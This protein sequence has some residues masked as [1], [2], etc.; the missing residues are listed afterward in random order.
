MP[1]NDLLYRLALSCVPGI[2]PVYAKKLLDR[3]GDAEAIFHAGSSGLA[4]VKGMGE[5]RVNA[6]LR[7]D[8]FG[9]LEKEM[10]FLEKYGIR[11]LF[12]NEKE[13]PQRLCRCKEAPILFYYKGNADLNAGRIISIVG[14][15][16]PTEYGKQVVER[17]V[18]ELA[19]CGPLVIS[20]LAFGIDAAA[21][22]A[23]LSHS[24]PT[25]AILGHG[26]DQIY[27]PEHKPLAAEIIKRGGLLT[28]FLP[29]QETC[30]HHFPL[31][32]RTVAGI[33]D[34]LVV[35]ETDLDGGSM[36]TVKNALSYQKKI[37]AFPGRLTDKKSRGCNQLIQQG[38][39]RLL[40]HTSELITELGWETNKNRSPEQ[41]TIF[42]PR[43]DV[44]LNENEKMALSLLQSKTH[45]SVDELSSCMKQLSSSTIA[46]TLI[47]LEMKGLILSLPGKMYS[48]AI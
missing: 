25:V 34:A 16:T 12:F 20:G 45:L 35:V 8:Q 38:S 17:L 32:N 43:M 29:H 22:K 33:C 39:A 14:T 6:I 27:P 36:L 19:G 9:I 48:L 31:R 2:G 18:R 24:L 40:L 1:E 44:H 15:R 23:A 26:L 47:N 42:P 13:Y 11:C 28:N 21:H 30:V 5:S 41:A 3:F 46:M 4:G 10:A 7:F 37:F